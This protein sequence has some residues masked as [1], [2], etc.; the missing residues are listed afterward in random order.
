[1]SFISYQIPKLVSQRIMVKTTLRSD[2]TWST[3][4]SVI[5]SSGVQISVSTGKYFNVM[6]S[7]K[8]IKYLVFCIGIRDILKRYQQKTSILTRSSLSFF[9]YFPR[10][11]GSVSNSFIW[12]IYIVCNS[13]L[14]ERSL[15][16]VYSCSYG[17]PSHENQRRSE[18]FLIL[19]T[20]FPTN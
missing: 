14:S 8:M 7:K 12:Y 11:G 18:A 4:F 9:L 1:M 17:F 2:R 13:N 20:V 16:A 5:V 3:T 10:S 15:T 6:N 19:Y